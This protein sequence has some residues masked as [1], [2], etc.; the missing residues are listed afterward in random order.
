MTSVTIHEAK[1]QLS[2][3]IREALAG[4]EVTI[5]Q[6]RSGEELVKLI[7]AKPL[8]REKRV[9]GWLAHEL[10]SPDKDPLA[11]GFWDP[12]PESE[13]ALWEGGSEKKWRNDSSSTP[14]P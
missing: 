8:R 4:G 10:S 6:G 7:P 1:T 14:T 13:L 2:R 11:D 9:L 5:R 3:L 12:L